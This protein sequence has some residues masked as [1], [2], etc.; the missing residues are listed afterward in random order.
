M[1]LAVLNQA[2]ALPNIRHW[3]TVIRWLAGDVLLAPLCGILDRQ[4]SGGQQ[5]QDGQRADRVFGF[6]M[7]MPGHR[8]RQIHRRLEIE[9][10]I[11]QLA[12]RELLDLPLVGFDDVPRFAVARGPMLRRNEIGLGGRR[13]LLSP[14]PRQEIGD[15]PA[16]R[17]QPPQPPVPSRPPNDDDAH[18]EEHGDRHRVQGE[19]HQPTPEFQGCH[20]LI[21]ERPFIPS[22]N[23][24]LDCL[25]FPG[26]FSTLV[27]PVSI[28]RATLAPNPGPT[29]R[30]PAG[31]GRSTSS[32]PCP[33]RTYRHTPA[34]RWRPRPGRE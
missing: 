29:A 11:G 7:I 13:Q 28:G 19:N 21:C 9:V 14:G 31:L 22:R 5:I 24:Q 23:G 34:P 27:R 6:G 33:A 20:L 2:G 8:Q 30:C 26:A 4:L 17:R 12:R 32:T 18:R 3:S 1:L 25:Y 10:G 16:Q 15:D